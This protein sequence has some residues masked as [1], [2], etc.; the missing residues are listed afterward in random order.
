MVEN[1]VSGVNA[2]FLIMMLN[3]EVGSSSADEGSGSPRC[4]VGNSIFNYYELN[5]IEYE[6]RKM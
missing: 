1:R 6:P 4:R 2:G 3:S 5:I